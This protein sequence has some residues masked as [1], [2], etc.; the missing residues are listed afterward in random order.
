MTSGATHF[1]TTITDAPSN[2]NTL[3]SDGVIIGIT[4]NGGDFTRGN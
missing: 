1:S 3:F 2:W 4:N